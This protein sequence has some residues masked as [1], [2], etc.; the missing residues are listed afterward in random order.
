MSATDNFSFDVIINNLIYSEYGKC[1]ESLLLT[2]PVSEFDVVSARTVKK[3][4]NQEFVVIAEAFIE[5]HLSKDG[6]CTV[7]MLCED[8]GMSATKFRIEMRKNTGMSPW[9]FI[10]AY[11]MERAKELLA[12]RGIS[13]SEIADKLAFYDGKYFGKLF[14]KYYHQSP[15][16]Y[17]EALKRQGK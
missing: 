11:R 9:E 5:E 12:S 6:K 7:E 1:F 13:I 2:F 14:K 8:M 10:I 16:E 4:V 3:V 17:K 15:S